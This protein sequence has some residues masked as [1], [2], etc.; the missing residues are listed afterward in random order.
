ME[1]TIDLILKGHF[2]N[3]KTQINEAT[4]QI[5]D[6]KGLRQLL[7]DIASYLENQKSEEAL[8]LLHK[9]NDQLNIIEEK[10]LNKALK[11][12]K[13]PMQRAGKKQKERSNRKAG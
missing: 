7:K 5:S 13:K 8:Q 1:S 11:A 6:N 9:L 12:K 2:E 3:I 10:R 4:T